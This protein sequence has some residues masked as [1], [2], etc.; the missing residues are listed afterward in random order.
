MMNIRNYKEFDLIEAKQV[1]KLEQFRFAPIDPKEREK[2][3]Q[4]LASL[5]RR[6]REINNE[7]IQIKERRKILLG[8]LEQMEGE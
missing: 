2:I 4:E 1:K 3:T 8:K 7:R 5:E 6:D